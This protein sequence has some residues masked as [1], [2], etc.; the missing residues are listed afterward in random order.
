MEWK[1]PPLHRHL[2]TIG[3][4]PVFIC[5]PPHSLPQQPTGD[6]DVAESEAETSNSSPGLSTE[7]IDTWEII[8]DIKVHPE[9]F[10]VREIGW[11][12]GHLSSN[13]DESNRRFNV[14][15]GKGKYRR[16][17]GWSR[18]I[19]GL[20][21]IRN[22]DNENGDLTT[23]CERTE[24][25]ANVTESS[26][27]LPMEQTDQEK[28][29]AC[30]D[31]IMNNSVNQPLDSWN[32][33]LIANNPR[34]ISDREAYTLKNE[35]NGRDTVDESP[36]DGLRR[37]LTLCYSK[38][39]GWESEN[40]PIKVSGLGSD[41][42][43]QQMSRLQQSAIQAL[44]TDEPIR[45]YQNKPVWIP[46]VH[47]TRNQLD[48]TENDQLNWKLLHQYIRSSFPL[49]K[50]EASS[51]G[52]SSTGR[53]DIPNDV[54]NAKSWIRVS[55]DQLFFP[56]A[57]LLAMP[58]KD[59]IRLYMF[60]NNGPVAASSAH[61]SRTRFNQ[62]NGSNKG[63]SEH[64]DSQKDKSADEKGEVL[65][66]LKPD[67]PRNERR[68]VHQA[69]TSSRR[70]DF[71]TSTKNDV[72]L[73]EDNGSARTTA[74]VVQWSR[75]ALQGLKKKRKRNGATDKPEL[76][77]AIFCV[78]RKEQCEHQVAIKK[79]SHTLKCH[80][81][82]IGLAGIKDMQAITYQFCTL[83]NVDF[84]NVLNANGSLHPRVQ[85]SHFQHVIGQDALLDRGRLLGSEYEL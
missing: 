82:D 6:L 48:T 3:I 45:N 29:P 64:K 65:L 16:L 79:L 39:D 34:N 66:R 58:S 25:T 44:D 61:R 40:K 20:E 41:D 13:G 55:V 31:S 68:V 18:A 80:V 81:G 57:P 76:I 77:S 5:P 24:K 83:R 38:T 67:L 52:P 11:A 43:I 84:K 8:G 12:P 78:L 30:D 70:R 19:A 33:S 56:I 2:S 23:N 9:D 42:T 63:K 62:G 47:I 4:G 69:L 49:L 21:E 28:S 1:R 35:H 53:E 71:D 74:I 32:K 51:I 10:L 46:T 60:R 54:Y 7:I 26:S 37:I 59:L 22:N 72:P 17:H 14:Q 75:N 50:T 15:A 73:H 27:T 85:L 36:L